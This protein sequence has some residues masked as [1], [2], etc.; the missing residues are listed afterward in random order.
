MP[1]DIGVPAAAEL[2]EPAE[3]SVIEDP[4]ILIGSDWETL[5]P[6]AVTVTV[7]VLFMPDVPPEK[8]KVALPVVSVVT[9]DALNCP[10][11]LA[12]LRTCPVTRA[13]LLSRAVAVITTESEPSL[14][15]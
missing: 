1:I 7:M 5:D 12:I 3:V 2:A 11:E 14:L 13:F 4:A 9:V 15:T 8:V 10:P 6:D